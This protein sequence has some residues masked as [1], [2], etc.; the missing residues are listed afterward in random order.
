MEDPTQFDI[1]EKVLE[2]YSSIVKKYYPSI[3]HGGRGYRGSNF[4]YRFSN[5][6]RHYRETPFY[7][8]GD[9]KLIHWTS[10]SNLSSIINNKEIR[11]YNLIKS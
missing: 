11:V 5:F 7:Y 6:F 9:L 8:K 1:F 10:L 3:I 2:E 4:H